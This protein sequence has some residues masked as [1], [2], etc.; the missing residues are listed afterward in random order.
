MV[1]RSVGLTGI[2]VVVALHHCDDVFGEGALVVALPNFD[3]KTALGRIEECAHGGVEQGATTRN[4]H[5]IPRSCNA[6]MR[7]QGRVIRFVA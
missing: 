1:M 4:S 2:A 5:S 3:L 6:A 7:R